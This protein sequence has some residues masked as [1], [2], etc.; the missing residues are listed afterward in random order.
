MS[1]V[2]ILAFSAPRSVRANVAVI[3][4]RDNRA[5]ITGAD[6]SIARVRVLSSLLHPLSSLLPLL[7]SLSFSLSLSFPVSLSCTIP[8][9]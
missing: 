5:A 3:N 9:R 2:I 8:L 7:A 6:S 4:R 1:K